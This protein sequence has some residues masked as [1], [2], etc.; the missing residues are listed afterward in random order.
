MIRRKRRYGRTINHYMQLM[1]NRQVESPAP[2]EERN[3]EIST[4]EA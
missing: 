3:V 1:K 4:E 2:K